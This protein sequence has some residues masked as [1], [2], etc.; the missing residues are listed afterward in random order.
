MKIAALGMSLFLTSTVSAAPIT[1]VELDFAGSGAITDI[2]SSDAQFTVVDPAVTFDSI[3]TAFTAIGGSTGVG[4]WNYDGTG[5]AAANND[6]HTSSTF[7]NPSRFDLDL[8]NAAAGFGYTI[9]RVEIDVRASNKATTGWDFG[10]RDLAT[11]ITTVL[12]GGLIATQSGADPIATY[13]IDLASALVATDT[14]TTWNQSGTGELRFGFFDTAD[15]VTVNDNLQIAAIRVIGE[16]VP[17][18]GSLALLGLG[19]VIMA[20]RRRQS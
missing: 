13:G 5:T 14:T 18:P 8:G 12:S 6:L 1:L 16:S 10:F 15:G 9:T 7:G 20:V 4:G 3:A 17:E 11:N 19:G 2:A